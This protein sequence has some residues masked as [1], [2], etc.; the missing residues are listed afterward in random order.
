MVCWSPFSWASSPAWGVSSVSAWL[1]RYL[2]RERGDAQ[3]S[4][5]I[6]GLAQDVEAEAVEREALSRL[7]D[8][9]RFVDHDARDGGGLVVGNIPVHGPVQVADRH[10]AVD[11]HRAVG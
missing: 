2:A 8:R 7:G 5:A 9:A 3:C 11:I 6:A 1:G 4:D 10:C